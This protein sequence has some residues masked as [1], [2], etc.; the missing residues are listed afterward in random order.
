MPKMINSTF[1]QRL[2]RNL[3]IWTVIC[4]ISAGPSFVVAISEFSEPG[5][6]IAMLAGVA[7][8]AIAY[9][10][11]SS[12][13]SV[14]HFKRDRRV[15][16]TLRIGYVSRM[17]LSLLSFLPPFLVVD[18]VCGMISVSLTGLDNDPR[19]PIITYITTMVQGV[20][21]NVLLIMFMGLVYGFLHLIPMRPRL[22][23][24]CQNCGYDLR[25]SHDRCPECGT[26]I[27]PASVTDILHS[28]GA[29][30]GP[31]ESDRPA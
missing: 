12:T 5:D 7:T 6:V 21:L 20:I 2:P 14:N 25:A 1:V 22:T 4:G 30:I 18:F 9:T 8:F 19:S 27:S 10:I 28:A 17:V 23:N 15:R 29:V 11:L 26:P 31:D 16:L 13:G 24:L 3:A